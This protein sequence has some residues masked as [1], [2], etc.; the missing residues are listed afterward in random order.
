MDRSHRHGRNTRKPLG[1][2]KPFQRR[3]KEAVFIPKKKDSREIHQFRSIAFLSDESKTPGFCQLVLTYPFSSKK[4]VILLRF[5][6]K[7]DQLLAREWVCQ[8]QLAETSTSPT[9]TP[10]IFPDA[11]QHQEPG[12]KSLQGPVGDL[13]PPGV[14]NQMTAAGGGHRHGMLNILFVAAFARTAE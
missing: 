11:W 5:S 2:S 3:G 4:L 6:M 12:L 13:L 7:N 10:L 1:K 9:P 8:H 14:H